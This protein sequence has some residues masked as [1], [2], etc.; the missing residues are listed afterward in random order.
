[1]DTERIIKKYPNR[2]L[3]DTAVSQYVTLGDIRTLVRDQ[4]RFRVVDAKTEED[5]TRSILLQILLEEEDKGSPIF[6]TELLEQ[7]IRIYG[8][9][10]QEFMSRYLQE[11]LDVFL[12]QQRLVQE[13][14]AGLLKQGP[15]SVF[16]GLAEQNLRLWQE[17]QQNAFKG[18]G[19]EP[20]QPTKPKSE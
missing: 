10:M 16:T 3:Y 8:D 12:R 1:M 6:S 5:L 20:P 2:R 7:F 17:F 14:M 11:S 15:L 19:P 13:Q 4:V 18:Y 9:S